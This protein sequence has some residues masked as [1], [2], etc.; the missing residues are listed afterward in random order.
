METI[1][2]TDLELPAGNRA[3]VVVATSGG[4]SNRVDLE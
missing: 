1:L 3:V 2:S 4:L